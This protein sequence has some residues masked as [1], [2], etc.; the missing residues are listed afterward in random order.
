[1]STGDPGFTATSQIH[2]GYEPQA[3]YRSVAVPIYQ[4]AAYEFPDYASARSMFALR[5]PG[6]TYTRTGN[7]TV[8]AFEQRIAALD[9][10]VAA[11]A[12]ATGQAAVA[13]ALLSLARGGQHIVASSKLYGGTVDLLTDTFADFG[14]EVSFADPL[15]P[16]VWRAAVRPTTRAFLTESIGNPLATLQDLPAIATV[17][18]DAGV[19]LVVDNTLAT[20]ALYRPLDLGADIVV[21]SATKFLGGHGTTLAGAVVDGGRFDFS[22]YPDKWPQITRPK[23]RYGGDVLW[24]RHGHGAYLALARSKYLHDL[25]PSLSPTSAAHILQGLE[26]LDIR[27]ARHGQNTREVVR[28]LTGHPAVAAVH[29][30]SVQDHPQ[31]ELAARDF[32]RGAGSVFSFDLAADPGQVEGFIDR[33][34]L[35][36]LVANVG[37][38]RSLVAH[39]AAMTHCRLSPE[40]RFA[41]GIADTTIRLSIGLETAGD[42]VADL[43]L[44]LAPLIASARADARA[45]GAV[46]PAGTGA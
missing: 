14:I 38:T 10:G 28:F 23:R 35:F 33:L 1:M 42:L 41:S 26:T 12:T 21:Y 39:P 45:V 17:A 43:D 4:T 18:H 25:G 32:P 13:V 5:E 27:V 36:K 31:A 29:H 30:P 8:A 6:F 44:A 16:E 3:P 11:L 19:P 22:R 20:P 37:D 9:G 46:A 15:H 2:A 34:R 7:P 24:E 40:H